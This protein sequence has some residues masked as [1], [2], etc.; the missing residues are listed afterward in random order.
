MGRVSLTL[1][2]KSSPHA[3][4]PYRSLSIYFSHPS[5]WYSDVR[6][7]Q[8]A[9]LTNHVQMTNLQGF[10]A[11]I[12][13]NIV[14][15]MDVVGDMFAIMRTCRQM[16]SLV[17]QERTVT[18]ATQLAP[19]PAQLVPHALAIRQAI[20]HGTA[21]DTSFART[22]N[23]G[24]EDSVN[25]R[26]AAV[27]LIDF[28]PIMS[29]F[30]L[31]EIFAH[32]LALHAWTNAR[33]TWPGLPALVLSSYETNNCLR[34]FYNIELYARLFSGPEVPAAWRERFF[35]P[36]FVLRIDQFRCALAFLEDTV[37]RGASPPRGPGRGT[38]S[39]VLW[40]NVYQSLVLSWITIPNSLPS[41]PSLSLTEPRR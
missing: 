24:F 32:L 14:L 10:P 5:L 31:A 36:A 40:A 34:A 22:W 3:S 29:F 39:F 17:R 16:H 27:P 7:L 15:H 23:V 2:S 25:E 20:L 4:F 33:S 37:E 41:W 11:E 13:L 21:G 12:L 1:T 8:K 28:A 38:R 26:L 6:H 35:F 18:D 30:R 19:I 9:L